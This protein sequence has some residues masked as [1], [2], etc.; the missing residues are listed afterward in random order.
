MQAVQIALQVAQHLLAVN[1]IIEQAR[2]RALPFFKNFHQVPEPFGEV[3]QLGDQILRAR[4]DFRERSAGV[5][6]DF[7]IAFQ[8]FALAGARRDL[9][10]LVPQ[11]P[12]HADGGARGAGELFGRGRIHL[13][14]QQHRIGAGDFQLFD[15]PHPHAEEHHAVAD[16]QPG[17]RGHPRGEGAFVREQLVLRADGEHEDRH[18]RQR[19]GRENSVA[20]QAA[21]FRIGRGRRHGKTSPFIPSIIAGRFMV[22]KEFP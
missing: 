17:G 6:G 14:V 1:R 20:P 7:G 8:W 3:L 13:V 16:L 5:I 21:A 19:A 2:Q 9:D 12:E 15:D 4:R 18:H 11:H 10:E 22:I